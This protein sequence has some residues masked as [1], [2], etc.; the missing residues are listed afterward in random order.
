[1]MADNFIKN[2]RKRLNMTQEEF[3]KMLGL[4]Q[5]CISSW[6]RGRCKPNTSNAVEII[7]LAAKYGIQVTL[8][9]LLI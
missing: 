9:D 7:K 2:I 5:V 4:R 8:E 1:M 6:E 3:G